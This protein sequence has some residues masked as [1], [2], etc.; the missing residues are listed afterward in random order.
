MVEFN[1]TMRQHFVDEQA[2]FSSF[3]ALFTNPYETDWQT[4]IDAAE[5]I[6]PDE[7]V[8]DQL[9]QLT[10]RNAKMFL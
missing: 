3:D 4:A 5:A 8:Q 6:L 2:A 9:Q 10:S 7:A 1:K